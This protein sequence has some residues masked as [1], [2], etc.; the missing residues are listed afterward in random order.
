M[1]DYRNLMIAGICIAVG[2]FGGAAAAGVLIV[3]LLMVG[4]A[5]EMAV[6]YAVNQ[7]A[8][9]GF[10]QDV[11]NGLA[12]DTIRMAMEPKQGNQP[13]GRV[14]VFVPVEAGNRRS[15]F[16][17]DLKNSPLYKLGYTVVCELG[18]LPCLLPFKLLFG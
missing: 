11:V 5:A 4:F 18:P 10:P 15:T 2:F 8:P 9:R 17:S 1:F 3:A 7:A 12:R 14:P 16:T 13:H 6:C